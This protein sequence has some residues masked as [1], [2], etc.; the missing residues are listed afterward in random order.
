MIKKKEYKQIN[1]TIKKQLISQLTDFK[2]NQASHAA[3][4]HMKREGLKA[5]GD[6]DKLNVENQTNINLYA[7]E[8]DRIVTPETQKVK[9]VIHIDLR[10]KN[11][12]KKR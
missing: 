11:P 3:F 5:G 4:C 12:N 8:L 9:H 1:K 6:W 7:N 10:H 2:Q